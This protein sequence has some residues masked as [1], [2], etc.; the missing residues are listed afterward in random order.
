MDARTETNW[1]DRLVLLPAVAIVAFTLL[2]PVQSGDLWWH[3]A[4]GDWVREHL[5]MPWRDPFSHTAGDALYVPQEYGSQVLYSLV[6]DLGGI[7]ALKVFG[8]LLGV[9]LVLFA[10]RLF[11]RSLGPSWAAAVAALFAAAY[12][13]K[14][15]LRPHL[16][17]TLVLLWL[18]ERLFAPDAT[19]SRG[20]PPS[21]SPRLTLG[22]AALTVG[23]VQLH[24]EAVFVP[25]FCL[26]GTIAVG[27]GALL[28]RLH[29]ARPMP[30][31]ALGRWST[32]FGTTL[33]A[34]FLS[35]LGWWPHRYALFKREIP[36]LYIDEWFPAW[37]WPSDPR[38]QVLDLRLGALLLGLFCLSAVAVVWGLRL[39]LGGAPGRG[40]TW[41]RLGLLAACIFLAVTARRYLW[42]LALPLVDLLLLVRAGGEPLAALVRSRHVPRAIALLAAVPLGLSH[43][44]R[45]SA[46]AWHEGRYFRAADERLLPV[47]A[48]ALL[49]ELG[50]EGNLF[51][52][53][54]WGGYLLHTLGPANPIFVDGRTTLFEAVIPERWRAERDS[55]YGREV[56]AKR[57]VRAIVS[58]RLIL[59][60]DPPVAYRP[61]DADRNWIRVHGDALAELWIRADEAAAL[62]RYAAWYGAAG[63]PFDRERGF[64][65]LAAW[66]ADER[67][68][69]ERDLFPP[70]VAAPLA[71]AVERVRGAPADPDAWLALAR[72]AQ[73]LRLGRNAR[74]ALERH[75]ET[76]AARE[77]EFDPEPWLAHLAEHGPGA[78]IDRMTGP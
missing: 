21:P 10:A 32:A 17:S 19:G 49:A 48:T 38:F 67:W 4:V 71:P 22:L 34:S 75:I 23:W 45:N 6:Q 42:M 7:A 59:G 60:T 30:W 64:V 24:A 16:I 20:E 28:D 61:P 66:I 73:N 29:F 31:T 37:I 78:T 69:R 58:R 74:Y 39:R 68:L 25:I 8:A 55:D 47:H 41:Q 76:R 63:V 52:P 46:A 15:E 26:M 57:D 62:D 1:I 54:D 18:F 14:W 70:A 2:G 27:L 35:P 3:L 11:R 50:P 9:G 40:P 77:P 12:A 51:H 65:E 43:F 53:Y 36:K 13:I 5:A 72:A 33:A 56:L 44:P